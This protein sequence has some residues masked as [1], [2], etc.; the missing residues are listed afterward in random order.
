MADMSASG[1]INGY[2]IGCIP[3]S[4]SGNGHTKQFKLSLISQESYSTSSSLHSQE[5]VIGKKNGDEISGIYS[6]IVWSSPVIDSTP[7]WL[8]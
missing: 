2:I 7:G 3:L 8:H 1:T 6:A 4:F 5:I